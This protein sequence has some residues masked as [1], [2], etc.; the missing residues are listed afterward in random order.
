MKKTLVIGA[1]PNPARYSFLAVRRLKQHGHEV[2][3]IGARDG[4]VDGVPILTGKP[5]LKNIDTVTLYLNPFH[6][7]EYYGYVIGLKP[8]RLIFNPGAE[9]PVFM[10]LAKK[11]GINVE[12][13]CTLVLLSTGQY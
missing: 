13:A 2:V 8:E 11:S 6:Q 3:A 4:E 10:E 12:E 7:E 5:D 1:S 9:N